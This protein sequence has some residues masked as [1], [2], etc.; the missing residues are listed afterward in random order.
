MR[1]E[2]RISQCDRRVH[3]DTGTGEAPRLRAWMMMTTINFCEVGI[4]SAESKG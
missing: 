3:T 1:Q 2:L 4:T